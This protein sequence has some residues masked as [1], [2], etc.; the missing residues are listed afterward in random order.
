MTFKEKVQAQRA[1]FSEEQRKLGDLLRKCT[2]ELVP[3]TKEELN[4]DDLGF[5]HCDICQECFGWKCNK[6]PD[7]VCH[8]PCEVD[9]G[10]ITLFNGEEFPVTIEDD[11]DSEIC[12]FCGNPDERK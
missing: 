1:K 9:E 4:S 8:Y 11:P 3:L 12:I 7:Q 2:H 6:S 5:A 10:T